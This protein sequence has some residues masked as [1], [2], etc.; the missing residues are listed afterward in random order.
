MTL[1][2]K[3]VREQ[4]I[5]TCVK[6]N[7]HGINQGTSGNLSVRFG[8]RFLITPSSIPYDQ[9]G[10]EDMVD[11]DWDGKYVG[12]R[13]S[14]EWRFHRDILKKRRD[15]DVVLHCHSI[16]ATAVACHHQDIPAFHYIVGLMGGNTLRCAP[17]ATFGTQE[18]SNAAINALDG[19]M[20]CLL[21]QH[22]QIS[23]GKTVEDALAMALE[24]ESLA[25][26]YISAYAFGEPP[27]LPSSEMDRVLEQMKRM[28][29]G[30]GPEAEDASDVAT[31]RNNDK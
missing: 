9:L 20:A 6:M 17:Y 13:P 11:M 2:E 25:K 10:P 18:L 24:V 26:I 19:R 21:A 27:V 4:M 3:T 16:F 7:A 1:N 12:L 30:K 22:G 14:S 29:Y 31:P 8:G 5:E 28:S 23:I 15:V